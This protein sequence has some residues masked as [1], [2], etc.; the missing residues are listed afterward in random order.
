VAKDALQPGDLLFYDDGS[1][2]P[3]AIHHVGMYVGDGRMV[4]APTEGK[5][6]DVRPIR[7]DGHYIGARRIV[8]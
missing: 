4:D 2:N 1:G 8:G 3:A 5:L 7:S 6:V